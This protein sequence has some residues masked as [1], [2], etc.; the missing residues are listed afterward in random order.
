MRFCCYSLRES[1]STSLEAM[2][3]ELPVAESCGKERNE[4]QWKTWMKRK[5]STA[6]SACSSYISARTVATSNVETGT[7]N[8]SDLLEKRQIKSLL[9]SIRKNAFRSA[10]F[11][12]SLRKGR[13]TLRKESSLRRLPPHRRHKRFIYGSLHAAL[14][15]QL[16]NGIKDKRKH[17]NYF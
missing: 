2:C 1:A 9:K 5:F 14:R 16:A 13:C 8:L 12:R 17:H 15:S 7:A 4:T 10:N 3:R 11:L 6:S